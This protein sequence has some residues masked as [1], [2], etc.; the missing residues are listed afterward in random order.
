MHYTRIS[1]SILL[2]LAALLLSSVAMAAPLG[3]SFTYDGSLE[4]GGALA[5]GSYDLKF[6]LFDA[7]SGGNLV[8]DPLTNTAVSAIGPA[9]P[10]G[11][12]QGPQGVKGDTGAT[13]SQGPQGP[14][15]VKG[16][17]GTT[18]S[19]GPQGPKGDT[20]ATGLQG[21]QG[22]IGPQGPPGTNAVST[23]AISSGI[24]FVPNMQVYRADGTFTV[25]AGVTRI[26]VELWGAG[27]GGG[28]YHIVPHTYCAVNGGGGGSGAYAKGVFAVT[29]GADYSFTCGRG[30]VGGGVH[31]NGVSDRGSFGSA[32]SFGSLLTAAGGGSGGAGSGEEGTSCQG[33]NGGNGGR[34]E[35]G[36]TEGQS[37]IVINGSNGQSG[38]F[39]DSGAPGTAPGSGYYQAGS[40]GYGGK[41][42]YTPVEAG[43]GRDGL[44]IIYY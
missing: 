42:F 17:T 27:G 16:D 36:G 30:G 14:Q 40:G 10:A 29:P 28:A 8:G 20:G 4:A 23:N 37:Y 34:Q 41:A 3:T 11:G 25:P 39:A 24:N 26:M 22:P 9:G 19:Q 12:P 7:A 33:G 18:G 43:N 44:L 2:T 15:G 13:G 1:H 32:T 35:S 21:L 6:T 5:S 38:D 31:T